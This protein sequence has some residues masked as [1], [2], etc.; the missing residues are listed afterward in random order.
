MQRYFI[1]K[2]NEKEMTAILTDG[3]FHHIKNVMRCKVD[4]QII[5]CDKDGACY[6]SSIMFF[7]DN[8]VKCRLDESMSDNDLPVRVDIA[9]ALIRRE[10]FEYMLQKST[11]LGVNYI[12]PTITKN[13]IVKLDGSKADKKVKRWN[14]ITKEASEQAHRSSLSTVTDVIRLEDLNYGEYDKV[15]VAYE[16]EH[17][18][19]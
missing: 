1:D 15:L 11:E 13:V 12:I 2:L 14:L 16:Q 3:D 7:A 9:Q 8:I 6:K 4:D 18:K 19:I 10:K 5:V 17:S